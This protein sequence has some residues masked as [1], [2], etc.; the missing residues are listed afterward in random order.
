MTQRKLEGV[1]AFDTTLRDGVQAGNPLDA[2]QRVLVAHQLHELGVDVIEAG[3]P[4]AS[5]DEIICVRRVAREVPVCTAGLA[6]TEE[7][8]VR[9]CVRALVHDKTLITPR[10]H[11]FVGTSDVQLQKKLSMEPQ[12][13]LD[14]TGECVALARSYTE[15]VE[16]STED[17]SRTDFDFL[18]KII[19]VAI[20]AG[21]RTIN[22]PDTVGCSTPVKYG[23][24]IARLFEEVP[25]IKEYGVIVSVHCHD[26]LGLATANTLY[27]LKAGARQFESTI[28]GIGERAGNTHMAEVIMALKKNEDEFGLKTNI[29]TRQLGPTS[30]LLATELNYEVEG[31]KP[32]VGA[33]VF[34][35]FSGIHRDGVEKDPGTYEIMDPE[36]VGNIG[37]SGIQLTAHSG[38]AGLQKYLKELGYD[39]SGNQLRSLAKRMEEVA[40]FRGHLDEHDLH[41]LMQESAGETHSE[42]PK[43]I[44]LVR[45]DYHRVDTALSVMVRLNVLGNEIEA[46]GSGVGPLNATWSAIK[47]ALSRTDMWPK[48]AKLP[49]FQMGKGSGSTEAIGYA[50]MQISVDE[51]C[52]YGYSTD[53]DIIIACAR[54]IISSLNHLRFSPVKM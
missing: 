33:K 12:L 44:K 9:A 47:T 4:I 21:A 7:K 24:L 37:G 51:S 49:Q 16:Y 29:D 54:C 5:D 27:G 20:K 3:F 22:V 28:N 30:R 19:T 14:L 18:K 8:D 17:G 45:L 11:V 53:T 52:G 1:K 39:V 46:S 13:A 50:R 15:D 10:I 32:V 6:R 31:T 2:N 34:Q 42:S 40:H 35:H 23:A 48:G 43:W 36:S 38:K 41:M 25:E 26:D